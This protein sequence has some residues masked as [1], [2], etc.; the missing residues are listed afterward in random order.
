[1]QLL[2]GLTWHKLRTHWQ[3]LDTGLDSMVNHDTT[4]LTQ[5]PKSLENMAFWPFFIVLLINILRDWKLKN[6]IL[7]TT[8]W[9]SMTKEHRSNNTHPGK[10][11]GKSWELCSEHETWCDKSEMTNWNNSC[12][13]DMGF[14]FDQ[15][16]I[17]LLSFTFSK[18]QSLMALSSVYAYLTFQP[19]LYLHTYL[20]IS[21]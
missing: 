13:M 7:L 16:I 21:E 14:F 18:L 6:I 5:G 1:M 3:W 15:Q 19:V 12:Q 4:A 11:C 20:H 10:G 17:S 8:P 2:T 9:H